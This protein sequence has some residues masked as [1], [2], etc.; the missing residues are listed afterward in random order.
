M[1]APARGTRGEPGSGTN[2][3][4]VPSVDALRGIAIVAMIAY[5]FCFDLRYFGITTSD[6]YRDPFWLHARTAI[7]SSFL[8]LAGVSLA[9]AEQAPRGTVR[10]WRHFA[11]IA[12]CALAVS[13]ASYLLFP[14]SYIWFGVLHAIAVSL[15]LIR[16]F[17]TRPALA[18]AA[19]VAVIAAG[20]GWTSSHFDNRAL[21]WVGFMPTKPVTEDY[22][23]LF[24]WA[25]VMLIG[26]AA[27]HALIGN[28]FVAIASFARVPRA[29]QWLGRHSLFVYMVHQPLLIGLVYL[30]T[31]A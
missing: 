15:M 3:A 4:R 17:A 12:A 9:L 27:G 7:L 28:R 5:H 23:P 25:G 2:V 22:V 26:V 30:F 10:F 18:F 11:R 19:G 8:L 31:R 16:P 1:T 24:P 6:F 29:V 20:I 13:L 14:R 21:G